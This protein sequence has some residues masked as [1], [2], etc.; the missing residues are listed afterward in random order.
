[1]KIIIAGSREIT[2]YDFVEKAILESGWIDKDTEIISG[3]A[4][5]V[6]TLAVEF[7]H[8]LGLPLHK[9]PADWK[10][11]GGAAGMIRNREMAEFGDAMIAI[12]D[13]S[14]RGTENMITV[15]RLRG[16]KIIV[17]FHSKYDLF[18]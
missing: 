10:K 2:D 17:K 15:A 3:M 9:F 16:L 5:G 13:G 1:M 8:K 12:W 18:I 14:S 11:Y 4:R 7:A 6:D